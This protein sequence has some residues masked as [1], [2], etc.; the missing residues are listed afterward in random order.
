LY[1]LIGPGAAGKSVLLKII[2]GLI[3]PESGSVMVA[4]RNVL[5]MRIWLQEFQAVR[6]AFRAS[7][8]S[9][10]SRQH[11]LSAA[12]LLTCRSK[13]SSSARSA[14]LRVAAG[15]RAAVAVRSRRTEKSA[16]AWRHG[17]PGADRATTSAAGLKP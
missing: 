4:N 14:A 8:T 3:R 11:R 9:R 1:G 13:R 5:A 7:S 10:Q 15:L 16:S 17:F 6:H 12:R 2:A